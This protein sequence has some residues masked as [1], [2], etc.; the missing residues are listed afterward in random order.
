MLEK[1]DWLICF[2]LLYVLYQAA[3]L[4][5][6]FIVYVSVGLCVEF[7]LSLP[8]PHLIVLMPREGSAL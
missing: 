2:S 5:Q 1:R 8:V 4:F 7:I 3:P 6:F